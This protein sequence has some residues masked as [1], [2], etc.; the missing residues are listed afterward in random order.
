M[1]IWWRNHRIWKTLVAGLCGSAA[2]SLLMAFKAWSG[3]L[4]AFQPYHSLQLSLGNWLGGGVHPL[5]PWALSF[6]NG[7]TLVSYAF[8]VLYARLPGRGGAAKGAV[9]GLAGWL[10]MSLVFFPLIGLGVF[11]SAAGSNPGPAVFSLAMILAY[12]VVLG[13]TYAAIEFG[14]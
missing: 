8:G 12:S 10:A 7:A 11:A 5:V 14:S 13:M 9:F 4:P 2:H 1:T 3:W 6:L